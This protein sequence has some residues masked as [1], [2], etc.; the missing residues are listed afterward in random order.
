MSLAVANTIEFYGSADLKEWNFLSAFGT[1]GQKGGVWEC[2]DLFKLKV[3]ET[4]E[5]RWVL[6]VSLNPGGPNGGSGTQYFV[7]DF[8]GTAFINENE[9]ERILWLDFGADNYA[10]VSWSDI[11]SE[12][13][14]RI[15]IGWM[16]NWNYAR[17]APTH[18]WR[19]AM[20]MPR[21]LSL[22]QTEKGIRIVGQPVVE[23]EDLR[24]EPLILSNHELSETMGVANSINPQQFE[25]ELKFSWDEDLPFMG[26]RLSNDLGNEL[27]FGYDARSKQYT[28]DRTKSRKENL[29]S[30][31]N[32]EIHNIP[33][34]ARY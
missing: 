8:D 22:K 34:C 10:G 18:P 28:F 3:G 1:E 9:S 29:G 26:L 21:E 32:T 14:R 7:G 27:L 15:Y 33:H 16:S 20:T 11:P 19:S 31:F 12:D 5:E 4:G 17:L 2:P 30:N 24:K 13:G 25:A 6:L 23:L